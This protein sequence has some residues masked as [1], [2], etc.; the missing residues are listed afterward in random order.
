M[1]LSH[2][3]YFAVYDWRNDDYDIPKHFALDV[4][5]YRIGGN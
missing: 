1:M 4:S 2:I 3:A 5:K